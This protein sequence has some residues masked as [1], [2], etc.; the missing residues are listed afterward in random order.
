MDKP[1][2]QS[3]GYAVNVGVDEDWHE[4][5]EGDRAAK[6]GKFEFE[7]G[8]RKGHGNANAHKGDAFG[9]ERFAVFEETDEGNQ[10]KDKE[11]AADGN[12]FHD[13]RGLLGYFEQGIKKHVILLLRR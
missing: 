5:R 8:K 12:P 4:G 1:D 3:V 9:I 11:N 10:P 2:E 13:V 6:L 7:H